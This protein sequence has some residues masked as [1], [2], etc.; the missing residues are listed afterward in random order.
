MKLNREELLEALI[1]AVY[2]NSTMA[3]FFHTA[4][5]EQFEL[6]ATEEK[7]LL[8]LSG[9]PLTA[10]EIAQNI[11]LTTAAV[12]NLIDRLERKGFVRRVRDMQDRRRVIVEADEARQAELMQVFSSLQGVFQDLVDVYSD[13]QLAAI[14]DFL[15]RTTQH[16]RDAIERLSHTKT[17]SLGSTQ[18]S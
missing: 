7:T 3:V 14:I 6:G 5:A 15:K 8:M 2:E 12:T 13:D 17:G 4:V 18:S 1:P 11:G 10:G 9:G 16:S